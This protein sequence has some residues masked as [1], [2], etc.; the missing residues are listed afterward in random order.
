[1]T[2][3]FGFLTAFVGAV[4]PTRKAAVLSSVSDRGWFPLIRES[5]A[6]AWQRNVEVKFD[7]VVTNHAVFACV[8]LAASDAAKMRVKLVQLGDDGV[9]SEVNNP[10]YSPVLR[11][12]NPYQTRIQFFESWFLSKLLNGNTYVLKQRDA[13]NVVVAMFVLDPRRVKPLVAD[14]GAVFYQLSADNLSGVTQD[15]TVPAREIIHDRSN[16]LFHPLVGLSP[17][18]ASGLAATQGLHIQTNSA[19]FFGNQSRPSGML[20]APATIQKETAERL[21]EDWER[22]YSGENIG[23]VAVLGDGLKFESMALTAEASQMVEQ[24][25]WSAEVICSTFH[26]P[27]YKIGIGAMPTYNNIQSLNVEYY[28]QCLQK[29]IEDAEACLDEGLGMAQGIGTEFD[30]DGLLRMD[31]V[32]QMAALK[33]GV[34][35]GIMAPNEARRK[36]D[37]KPVAGGESPMIQE[38]NYSLAALA[39]RDAKED[40]WASAAPAPAPQTDAPED[41]PDEED[42]SS[43]EAMASRS[44]VRRAALAS[45][46][47]LASILVN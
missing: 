3:R 20:T 21:K 42:D 35:A 37:L 15:I 18:Y 2:E 27:P 14:D 12:P 26:I 33:E 39:K 5:F 47:G 25:K 36:L 24:L 31:T 40:P 46:L 19:N 6:G 22:N 11:K 17:I 13:R 8:T 16:C 9:W 44:L 41:V 1:M 7:T 43:D 30:L 4:A 10:A 38:Q 28:S 23:R 29:L 34:G 32:T 45:R